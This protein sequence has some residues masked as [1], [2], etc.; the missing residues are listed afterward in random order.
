[1]TLIFTLAARQWTGAPDSRLLAESA[2]SMIFIRLRRA[3]VKSPAG[4]VV[5]LS[6]RWTG[7]SLVGSRSGGK[8]FAPPCLPLGTPIASFEIIRSVWQYSSL[9]LP[10]G[11]VSD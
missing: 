2:P 10:G 11:G 5:N 8:R 4:E 3:N 6:Q 7:L 9:Y 1:L